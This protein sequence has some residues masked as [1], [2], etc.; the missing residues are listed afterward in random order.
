MDFAIRT[1]T[2]DDVPAYRAVRHE[3]LVN[4]PEA[5]G[6]SPDSLAKRSDAELAAMFEQMTLFGVVV[7]Q[8]LCGL[9]AFGQG[10]GERERHRGGLYQVYVQPSL[11][12]TGAAPAL[13]AAVLHYAR[14]RVLQVHLGVG[15]HNQPAIRLYQKAGFEIYRTEPR[16]LFVNGRYIDEHL[17]VRFLDEAPGKTEN[18]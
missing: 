9:A 4:H 6:S 3:A 5:Y 10:E 16:A 8:R 2:A 18:E 14:G 12:G 17:M 7:E 15:A 11:R 13:I 1:L